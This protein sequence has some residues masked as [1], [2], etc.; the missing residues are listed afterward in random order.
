ML[1]AATKLIT[2][3][4]TCSLSSRPRATGA[5]DER[6]AATPGVKGLFLVVR[7]IT[8]L[9]LDTDHAA[10]VRSLKRT[11]EIHKGMPR[12]RALIIN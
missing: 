2:D 8:D 5:D 9:E 4:C 6:D 1:Y 7:L 10:R 3:D 12:G 11:N